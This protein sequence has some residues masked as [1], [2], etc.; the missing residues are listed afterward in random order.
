LTTEQQEAWRDSVRVAARERVRAVNDSIKRGL[1]KRDV[2]R[3]QCDTSDYRVVTQ[4]RYD[5]RIPVAVKV[6]CD[7]S[8][9]ETSSDLPASIYDPGEELFGGLRILGLVRNQIAID[10]TACVQVNERLLEGDHA[11]LAAGQDVV[12]D[13]ERFAVSDQR[14][15]R[16][17]VNH[18]LKRCDTAGAVSEGTPGPMVGWLILG[19]AAVVGWTAL[20]ARA[21]SRARANG[22]R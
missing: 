10:Q 2:P 5:N 12:G 15:N 3:S 11:I 1:R 20:A 19:L 14:G 18:H 4:T 17:G 8:K 6:P 13:S 22:S 7:L 16:R 21:R 9:L